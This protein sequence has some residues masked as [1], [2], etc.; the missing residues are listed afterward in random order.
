MKKIAVFSDIHGNIEA[1]DAVLKDIENHKVDQMICL[2]DLVGYL[3]FPNEV[4]EAVR[5]L[6]I[7]VIMGN[8]DQGVGFDLDDCGCAYPTEE[9]RK[10][11]DISLRWTQKEVSLENKSFLQNLLPQY[12]LEIDGQQIIFVH[13]SP[14]KIN[15]YLFEDRPESSIRRMFSEK[16]PKLLACGHTHKPYIR[17]IDS[18]VLLNDGSAGRPKDGIPGFTWALIEMEMKE[19]KCSIHRTVCE[20]PLLRQ[21]FPS[22]GLPLAFL[23]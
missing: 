2:G 7:P 14:R 3:P 19:I 18:M 4:I 1:L 9:E 21:R 8:Y 11:G 16:I 23:P 10:L 22:T 5:D 12:L 15:E 20:L 13:G 6:G 17:N